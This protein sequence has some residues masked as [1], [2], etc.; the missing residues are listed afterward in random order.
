MSIRDERDYI[1]RMIAVA[2]AAVARLRKM[3]LEGASATQIARDARS[4]QDKLL[5]KDANL[6][7]ALDAASAASFMANK[8]VLA[9]WTELIRVEAEAL[10]DAGENEQADA[11]ERRAEALGSILPK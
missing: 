2:A 4:E 6:L 8:E 9:V 5:G 1:L 10:R 7:N 3:L 11:R